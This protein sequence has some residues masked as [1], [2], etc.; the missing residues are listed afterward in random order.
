MFARSRWRNLARLLPRF[1]PSHRPAARVAAADRSGSR[2]RRRP[3]CRRLR[4]RR[5]RLSLLADERWAL[6]LQLQGARRRAFRFRDPLR[7][8][9]S[10]FGLKLASSVSVEIGA[11]VRR[12]FLAR[13]CASA[14]I[15]AA[16]ASSI[17]AAQPPFARSLRPIGS[18]GETFKRESGILIRLLSSARLLA[19][20]C[21]ACARIEKS[22]LC[23]RIIARR[24]ASQRRVRAKKTKN[25]AINTKRRSQRKYSFLWRPSIEQMEQKTYIT[26][27]QSA[28]FRP[29]LQ[30]RRLER[31]ERSLNVK[32]AE[33]RASEKKMRGSWIEVARA[34]KTKIQTFS[35]RNDKPAVCI[36]WVDCNI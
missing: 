15:A 4:A 13:T 24:T 35:M 21:A 26:K 29:L 12:R 18:S 17:G 32:P 8:C 36:C 6:C 14:A 3:R 1:R 25:Q 22:F 7:C 16:A 5:W 34:L 20:M 2:R 11:A 19:A 33:Q 31:V 28:H 30:K 10:P 27:R 23:A 9:L